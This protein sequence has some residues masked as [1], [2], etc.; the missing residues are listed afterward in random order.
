MPGRGSIASD[1]KWVITIEVSGARN[2]AEGKRVRDAIK[3]VVAKL[4]LKKPRRS[5]KWSSSKGL[6][7]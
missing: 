5:A 6:P 7:K 2:L 1:E 4:R 3:K